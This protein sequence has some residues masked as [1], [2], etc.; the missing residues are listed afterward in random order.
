MVLRYYTHATGEWKNRKSFFP[1]EASLHHIGCRVNP[2]SQI[3][4]CRW[5]QL[6]CTCWGSNSGCPWTI[7]PNRCPV[8]DKPLDRL[9]WLLNHSS[10][11]KAISAETNTNLQ[12][13]TLEQSNRSEQSKHLEVHIALHKHSQ[14]N[15]LSL[16]IQGHTPQ[17]IFLQIPKWI[18]EWIKILQI[19]RVARI[20]TTDLLVK[21]GMAATNKTNQMKVITTSMIEMYPKSRAI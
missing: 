11:K 10:T 15:T 16:H 2:R 6:F 7:H 18:R 9:F 14:G 21:D 19:L 13:M 12:G 8:V 5:W 4:A 1:H 3:W 20:K 17:R